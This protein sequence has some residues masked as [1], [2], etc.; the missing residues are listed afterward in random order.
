MNKPIRVLIAD[1]DTDFSENLQTYLNK[2][3]DI[4]AIN[5]VRDGQ[6][7]VNVCK[8][9]LPDLVLI[10]L[11]LPVLDSIKAIQAIL[12]QNERIRILG[13]STITNDRYAVEAI[14]AGAR[15]YIERNGKEDFEAIATAIR[16][17]A[18]GEVVLNP[19]L[20]SSI[21]QEFY[22]LSD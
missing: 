19:T 16:Q 14:K 9:A 11:H 6:G 21:L 20:A 8:E 2:Q 3:E 15:G 18:T 4:R 10:D 22:R 12:T 7:A 5:T 1:P 17:V 13:I